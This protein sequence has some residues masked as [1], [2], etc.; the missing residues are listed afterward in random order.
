MTTREAEA[1]LLRECAQHP[2]SSPLADG[3]V[4][5]RIDLEGFISRESRYDAVGRA[6]K[7]DRE[8]ILAAVR[9]LEA[10]GI[11]AGALNGYPLAVDRGFPAQ[12]AWREYN[13]NA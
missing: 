10:R 3:R 12:R 2:T 13:T 1:K 6:S 7:R 4:Q 5:I 9:R 11:L 8:A